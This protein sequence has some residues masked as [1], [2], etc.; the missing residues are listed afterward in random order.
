MAERSLS[1]RS[2]SRRL[3]ETASVAGERPPFAIHLDS[4]P[5][6]T[7]LKRTLE[8]P[9]RDLADAIAA[10][11]QAQE[12]TV[13]PSTMPLTK[14]ANTAIDR[15]AIDPS[16]FIEEIVRFAGSDLVSY[17]TGAPQ[18]LHARQAEAWDPVLT[19]IE[20]KL[21]AKF[22]A[23]SGIVFRS[24]PREALHAVRAYLEKKSSWELT[25]IHNMTTLTG[26]AL[27]ALMTAAGALSGGAVW[28]AA[29]VDE[30]WQIE[31][32]G[33]DAE[34]Q[35]RRTARRREFEAAL[36]FLALLQTRRG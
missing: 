17:R 35:A 12:E 13:D 31:H 8:L 10:E 3:Y 26:S 15:V 7:P 11:W 25:S 6:R 5:L 21:D 28:V 2:L 29:H 19:W 14:L 20:R 33:A 27:I 18:A 32:W 22:E 24:Q 4:K 9:S 30:D 36:L 1:T 23:I 16:S 34:H